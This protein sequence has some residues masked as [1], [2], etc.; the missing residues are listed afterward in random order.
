MPR[1]ARVRRNTLALTVVASALFTASAAPPVA[2]SPRPADPLR[3]EVDAVH[4]TG[5]VGVSAEVA[6]RDGWH[7]ARAGTSAK[8]SNS[9]MPRNGRFRV[10]S[11][12]KTFTATV[13]LQLVGEGRIALDDTVEHWLPGAVHGNG[14]DGRLITVRQ[15]LQHTSGVPD[16]L[17]D[18]PA[19]TDPAGYRA[20]RFR[21]YTPPE[22]VALAMRRPPTFPP[23]EGWA[24]SNTNYVL[25]AMIIE[26]V[27]G[28]PWDHEVAERIIRPL[29]MHGTSI[30]GTSASVSGPHARSYSTFGDATGPTIDVTT[31]NTTMATGSGSIISTTHDLSRFYSALLNGRLMA[32]A[33]FDDMTT[34]VPAPALGVRYGLGIG[35][36]PLSC[37]GAYFGHPGELLGY[38]TWIGITPDGSRT[39][40][41]YATSEGGKDTQAAMSTLVDREL[42]RA[43]DM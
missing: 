21:T 31:L 24:Y 5:V 33:Q 11:V 35:S 37:G 2:A 17:P 39:A 1:L 6:S 14:N 27:T 23:G 34:T 29:G 20:Q 7:I 13:I 22:L 28:R 40:V 12:T 16:A 25:A 43:P 38:R 4:R 26:R 30:P 18:I 10:G 42:C 19:L 15:L 3:N 9:P 41:V 36:I 8:G 32:S